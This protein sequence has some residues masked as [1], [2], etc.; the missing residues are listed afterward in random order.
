MRWPR[1]SCFLLVIIPACTSG[2]S[3][4]A[5]SHHPGQSQLADSDAA[6]L[7]RDAVALAVRQ[8]RDGYPPGP[9]S[10]EIPPPLIDALFSALS[11]VHRS[12]DPA[13]DTVIAI[14]RIHV[15]PE[16]QELWVGASNGNKWFDAWNSG[17]RLT[18]NAEIDTL[19]ERYAL[20]LVRTYDA[21]IGRTALLG[22]TQRL[23]V[24]PLAELF[25]RV[26][27]V[28]Y[29]EPNS[30]GGDGGNIVATPK[31]GGWLLD[32]SA[33]WGD[34]MT[35]CISRRYWTFFVDRAGKVSYVGSR[36]APAP[37]RAPP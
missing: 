30:Y 33:G 18:G 32:Y 36:G 5:E 19:M 17:N 1:Q 3:V 16:A 15:F 2:L 29:A 12:T 7:R 37:T 9:R 22:A 10:V 20:T 26:E 31:R 28:K 11:A 25:A 4:P 8:L 21:G 6:L 24:R 13:R 27:G 14:Y 34:C 23:N 35:G